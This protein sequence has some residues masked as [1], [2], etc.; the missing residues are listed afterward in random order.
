MPWTQDDA[1]RLRA[2]IAQGAKRVEYADKKIEY[3]DLNQ[4]RQLLREMEQELGLTPKMPYR[5][6]AQHNKGIYEEPNTLD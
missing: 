2:A 4:M 3:H 1:D 6:Y 5:R